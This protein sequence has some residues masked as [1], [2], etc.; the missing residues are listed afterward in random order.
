MKLVGAVVKDTFH[1]VRISIVFPIWIIYF[2]FC[3]PLSKSFVD[4]CH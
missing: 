1:M 3:C 2:H 4:V